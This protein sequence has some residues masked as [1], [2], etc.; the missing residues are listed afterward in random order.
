VR[1]KLKLIGLTGGIGAGKSTVARLLR[2]R[3]VPVID[4]DVLAREVVTPGQ[5]AHADIAAAWP[6]VVDADGKIDRKR[7]AA[8]VFADTDA[9]LRLENMT[10]PRIRQRVRELAADFERQDHDLAFLEAALL[11]ETGFHR[12]LDGLVLVTADEDQRVSRV[13]ARDSANRDQVRARLRA[14]TDDDK[15]RRAA[16]HIIDNSG[17]EADTAAQ[18]DRLLLALRTS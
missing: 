7:L 2:E 16:S 3:G 4:A 10:H 15:R 14:P 11:V 17:D 13:M 12:D 1:V 8:I 5:P 9:R 18:V 6:K